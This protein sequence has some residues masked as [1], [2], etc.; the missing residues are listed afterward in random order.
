MLFFGSGMA[1]ASGQSPSAVLA[2]IA[3]SW[4]GVRFRPHG[5]SR[6]GVDCV[7][8]ILC[9]AWEAGHA[10]ADLRAYGLRN[11]R[12]DRLPGEM[13]ARGFEPIALGEE[14][15]GDVIVGVPG[16]RQLHLAFRSRPGVIEADLRCARVIE[17]PLR[18]DD[19][20]QSGW[21]LMDRMG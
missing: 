15:P 13:L 9:V 16:P 5:R 10:L 20:W 17:R 2:A 11:N 21:R 8:L 18:G 6:F 7:G 19:C 4:I 12:L 14:I 1:S 3:S